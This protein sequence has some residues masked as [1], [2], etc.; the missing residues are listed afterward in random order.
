MIDPQLQHRF[1]GDSGV[2]IASHAIDALF[3]SGEK[4]RVILRLGAP[5]RKA[6]S[7]DP[8]DW[9]IRTEL[10]NLDSTDGPLAGGDSL[11][12]LVMGVKWLAL[13]LEIFE[14]AHACRYF[15]AGTEDV[16]DY[17]GAL[18]TY[19]MPTQP[20]EPTSGPTPGRGSP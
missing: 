11:H 19:Q 5:F 16:Y 8:E 3:P 17:R 12:T 20:P 7:R 10:E 1:E 15:W 18:A 9:W 2:D 13:R 14:K 4:R 6:E